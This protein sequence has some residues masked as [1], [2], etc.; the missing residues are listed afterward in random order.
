MTTYQ[1]ALSAYDDPGAAL[2][3]AFGLSLAVLATAFAAA[4]WSGRH[5]PESS[6]TTTVAA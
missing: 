6:V 4:V 5:D 3:W 2:R 1:V